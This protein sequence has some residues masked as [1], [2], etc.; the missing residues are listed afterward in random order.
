MGLWGKWGEGARIGKSKRHT[1]RTYDCLILL[2][3]SVRLNSFP[4]EQ[5]NGTSATLN[6]QF[7]MRGHDTRRVANFAKPYMKRH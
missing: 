3:P 7:I 5:T 6:E 1:A 2:S 4:G